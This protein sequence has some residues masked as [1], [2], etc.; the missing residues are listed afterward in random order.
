MRK[1][2]ILWDFT[3]QSEKKLEHNKLLVVA[4]QFMLIYIYVNFSKY[5][6]DV[7]LK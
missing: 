2:Q 5:I 4:W 3:I 7:Q 1:V 6:K